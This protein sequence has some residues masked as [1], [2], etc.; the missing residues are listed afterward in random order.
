MLVLCCGIKEENMT[1]CSMQSLLG[2][3]ICMEE[4]KLAIKD[5]FEKIFKIEYI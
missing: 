3:E 1:I 2:K 4:V 5:S